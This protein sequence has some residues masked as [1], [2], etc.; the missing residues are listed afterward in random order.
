MHAAGWRHL[1]SAE[2]IA[3]LVTVKVE[4]MLV[5][6]VISLVLGAFSVEVVLRTFCGPW[7]REHLRRIKA[8]MLAFHGA[9]GDEARQ[10]TLLRAGFTT[11]QCSLASLGI[12][13]GLLAVASL[14][15]WGLQWTTPQQ[16]TYLLAM[17]VAATAWGACRHHWRRAQASQAS[18][19]SPDRAG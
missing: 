2:A 4:V 15:P 10:R 13:L 3:A 6:L 18:N 17:S 19:N 12:L 9:N 14:A 16:E 5:V 1:V 7:F 8:D 11:L